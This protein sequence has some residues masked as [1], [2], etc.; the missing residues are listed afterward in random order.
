[1]PRVFH[2][3]WIVAVAFGAQAVTIGLTIIPFGL[4]T[5]PLVDEFGLSIAEVQFGV[6]AFLLVMAGA[7]AAV[8][9][10]LDRHSIRSLM[11]LGSV[12]LSLSFLGMSVANEPWQLWILFG[13]GAAVGVALAG[14]LAATTVIAKWFDEKRGLAVGVAAM[15]PHAGGF[16][17]TPLAGAWIADFGWRET[18]QIFAGIAIFIAPLAWIAVRNSPDEVGQ[19]VDGLASAPENLE[20][21]S[22]EG[23]WTVSEILHNRNFWALALVIGI[24]FGIGGGWG[25]NAPRFGEDLGYSVQHISILIGIAAGLGVPGTLLF[26]YLADRFDNAWLIRIVISM[27]IISFMTLAS[28]PGEALFTGAILFFGFAGGG[29]L[30]TYASFIGR[31]FGPSSFGSVMGLAGLVGLP[32]V[33][34]API[35]AGAVRDSSGSYAGALIVF[36]ISL[37]LGVAGLSLIRAQPAQGR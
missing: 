19:S 25:A 36:A 8:G 1:M 29:L 9:P 24:V 14:P 37:A 22:D 28:Q 32:F 35:V 23:G 12:I 16:L 3:W 21:N 18:L 20:A 4:F 33:T 2:G 5:S 30:P 6:S 26:G 17:F 13:L 31:L 27:Q 10:L 11:A 7:S 15:G 34:L